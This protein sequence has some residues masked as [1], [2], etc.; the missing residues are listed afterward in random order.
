MR[1]PS[2]AERGSVT[3]EFA[4]VVPAVVLLLAVCLSGIHVATLQLRLQDAASTAAR[5]LARGEPADI[6]AHLRGATST[7]RHAGGMVCVT[8]T[9]PS[10]LAGGLVGVIELVARSCAAQQP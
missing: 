6:G 7:A 9:L 4:L 10:P 5:S 1:S 2:P 3:A 8:A